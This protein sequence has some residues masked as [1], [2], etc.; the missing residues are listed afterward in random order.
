MRTG[1]AASRHKR[2]FVWNPNPTLD[3]V[4]S[5][6]TLSPG[7]VHRAERQLLSAG[8]KGTL[9][10]R[11][12]KLLGAHCDGAAPLAGASGSVVRELLMKER[13]PF[14]TSTVS[15]MTRLAITVSESSCYRD[16]VFNGP[17]PQTDDVAWYEHVATVRR[18]VESGKYSYFVIAGRPPLTAET[19]EVADI[20]RCAND[21]G[22]RTVY[23]MSSPTLEACLSANPWLVKINL[24]EARD[25]LGKDLVGADLVKLMINSGAQNVILTNGPGSVFG[26][27]LGSTFVAHP[28]V[29]AVASAVG[30]GDAFL[31]GLLFELSSGRTLV[32]NMI[33]TAMATASASAEN[34]QP[35]FF[36]VER[37]VSLRS[38]VI[39]DELRP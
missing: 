26:A 16:T 30:C 28:P 25:A 4:N 7:S 17:G 11:G 13:L 12:L 15:G 3:V 24:S 21:L 35:G 38:L 32:E 34:P 1:I 31:A 18:H 27:M 8:G 10:V 22:L 36:G 39:I 23:D 33:R 2:I 37:A 19:S 29:V 20:T 6:T 14:E 9:V 5:V